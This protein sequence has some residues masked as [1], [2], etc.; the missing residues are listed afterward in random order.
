MLCGCQAGLTL[1]KSD[2]GLTSHANMSLQPQI[3]AVSPEDCCDYT[4]LPAMRV[5][6]ISI[7]L[8]LACS[9]RQNLWRHVCKQLWRNGYFLLKLQAYQTKWLLCILPSLLAVSRVVNIVTSRIWRME[10]KKLHCLE[11]YP[12]MM[13]AD[14][15]HRS[16]FMSSKPF[17]NSRFYSSLSV[18]WKKLTLKRN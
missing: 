9:I 8:K 3:K 17:I 18:P 4:C 1:C 2:T 14:Q 5:N 7:L 10:V 16:Y 12:E 11:F 6:V 13:I 15:T